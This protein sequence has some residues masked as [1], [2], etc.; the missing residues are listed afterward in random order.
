MMPPGYPIASLNDST[1]DG[2]HERRKLSGGLGQL[3]DGVTGQDDFLVTR[4]YHVWPG[5][6]YVGWR[7]GSL[8]SDYVEMEFV[9]DKQRNFTSM[10]VTKC[11]LQRWNGT[12]EVKDRE[13]MGQTRLRTEKEWDRRG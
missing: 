3:T 8:G 6:D 11:I 1:Y 2:A 12:D 9:F 4:Q 5:Y 7:N 13:G 10:K